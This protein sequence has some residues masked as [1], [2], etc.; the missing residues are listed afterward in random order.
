VNAGHGVHLALRSEHSLQLLQ[1][2]PLV[3]FGLT[4]GRA[5]LLT[6]SVNYMAPNSFIHVFGSTVKHLIM[7]TQ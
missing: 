6:R 1:M 7:K 4:S 2:P 5:S 3:P